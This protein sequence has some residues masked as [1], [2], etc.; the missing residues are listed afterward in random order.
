M[1]WLSAPFHD[2]IETHVDTSRSEDRLNTYLTYI[3]GAAGGGIQ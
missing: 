2:E 1:T 3:I